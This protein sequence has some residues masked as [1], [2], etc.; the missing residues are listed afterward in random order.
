VLLRIGISD[1]R[2]YEGLASV[3]V[4]TGGAEVPLTV[5]LSKYGGW[6]LSLFYQPSRTTWEIIFNAGA[7]I[8]AA[9][10]RAVW[11]DPLILAPR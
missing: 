6:K 5:D 2:T 9:G 10:A 1:R 4:A 8:P 3:Q 7:E 11:A